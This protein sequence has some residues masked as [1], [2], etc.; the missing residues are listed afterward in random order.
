M[1]LL[2]FSWLRI[3]AGKASSHS[4]GFFRGI[5]VDPHKTKIGG[6]LGGW[7]FRGRWRPPPAIENMRKPTALESTEENIFFT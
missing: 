1:E 5:F 6:I 2:G 4:C 7:P 3:I